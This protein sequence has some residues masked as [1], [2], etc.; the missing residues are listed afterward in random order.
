MIRAA[1][2]AF[3]ATQEAPRMPQPPPPFEQVIRM[4]VVL[5]VPGMEQV[6]VRRDVVYKTIGDARLAADVYSPPGAPKDKPLPAVILIH[7]GPIPASMVPTP[8]DWGGFQ[9]LGQLLGASGFVAVTFNHRF[10][11]PSMLVEAAGDVRDLIRHVRE[12]AQVYGID[13]TRLALWAFSGGGPFLSSA[14]REG[15]EPVKALVAYYAALDLQE[16]PPGVAPGSANDLTDETRRAYS[17]V[18][19]VATG[20][21]PVPPIFVARAALDHPFLNASI[22]R[23]VAKA[24][25]RNVAIE[26]MNHEAGRHGFDILDDVDRSREILERTLQ[27]LRGRLRP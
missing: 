26:V 16:R 20:G 22:D 9:S 14:L 3:L 8:K 4:R 15:P 13:S 17:P 24:L 5:R 27:F 11:G 18:Y 21:R 6:A 19:H 12:N 10:H 1:L 2:L 25:E 23:F 7:G